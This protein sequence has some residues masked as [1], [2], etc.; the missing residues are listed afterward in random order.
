MKI[1]VLDSA[2][3]VDATRKVSGH[4]GDWKGGEESEGG[5]AKGMRNLLEC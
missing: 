5:I 4:Q 2:P 3:T 1:A